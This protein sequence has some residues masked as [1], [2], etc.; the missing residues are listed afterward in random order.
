[1]IKNLDDPLVQKYL[2]I[3]NLSGLLNK[4]HERALIEFPGCEFFVEMAVD[5]ESDPPP[6]HPINYMNF[7]VRNPEGEEYTI[8][9]VQKLEEFRGGLYR[10]HRYMVVLFTP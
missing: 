9:F 1:M 3:H 10:L 7:F 2:E 5:M 6:K 8:A 4:I